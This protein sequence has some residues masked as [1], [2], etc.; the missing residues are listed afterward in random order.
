MAKN[1][2]AKLVDVNLLISAGINPKTG[3]PYKFGKKSELYNNIKKLI[4]IK[5]EQSAVNRYGWDGT[6]LSISSPMLERFLFYRFALAF[7]PL[8]GRFYAMPYDLEGGLDFYGRENDVHP[9]P[10]AEDNSPA[11]QRQRELLSTVKLHVIKDVDDPIL[12]PD[13]SCVIIRDYTPQLN[14]QNG[15]PRATLQDG[16]IDFE[17]ALIPYMRTAIMNSVGV[18]GVQVAD[19]D[20]ANDIIEASNSVDEAALRGNPW[21]P[22]LKKLELNSLNGISFNASN[23]LMAM[24]GIDNLRESFY[25]LSNKGLYTKAEHTN[26]S[27]NEMDSPTSSPLI[28]GLK[29]RQRACDIIN[30][31]WGL[32]ISVKINEGIDNS[33]MVGEGIKEGQE[34]EPSKADKSED[35]S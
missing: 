13:R 21:I 19:S 5:D 26:D 10:F 1:N 6:H 18:Q 32:G 23:Y 35:I 12:D 34:N 29:Q 25:G 9:I 4:R 22:V 14:I 28:D 31:I 11:I 24:Q 27:E 7:F 3:L 30:K 8:E 33:P 2:N 17:A 15:L 16:I 20:E